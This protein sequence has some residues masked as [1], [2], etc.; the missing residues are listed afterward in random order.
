MSPRYPYFNPELS[1]S[2][3]EPHS[4]ELSEAIEVLED[5][6]LAREIEAGNITFAMIRPSVGPDANLLNLPDQMRYGYMQEVC[7]VRIQLLNCKER[8]R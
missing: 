8:I 3:I 6:I 7:L 2:G 4:Q 5:P 1:R